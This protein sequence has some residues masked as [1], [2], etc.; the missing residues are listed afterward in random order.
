MIKSILT[1]LITLLISFFALFFVHR[2]LQPTIDAQETEP[3]LQRVLPGADRFRPVEENCSWLGYY[4]NRKI[5]MVLKI[6]TQGYGGPIEMMVGIDTLKQITGIEISPR[7]ETPG[8]G[9]RV[10]EDWFKNQFIGRS[11]DDL[12]LKSEG[13]TI[14]AV[15]GAT[16]SSRAVVAELRAAIN[17]SSPLLA[18]VPAETIGAAQ[19]VIESTAVTRKRPTYSTLS[20]AEKEKLH[21]ALPEATNFQVVE[22]AT[23]W[24]GF[25]KHDSLC[26]IVFKVAPQGY[27]GPIETWVGVGRNRAIKGMVIATPAEGLKETAGLGA[28][29]REKEFLDQFTGTTLATIGLKADGGTIDAVSGATI[30][31]KAV[32]DGVRTGIEQYSKHLKL[33]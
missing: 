12:V 19:P 3:V 32:V 31:S 25:N 11:A 5:G 18:E 27:L 10:K 13:G 17:R 9:D 20:A 23:V 15:T 30:S 28:R 29:V 14:D 24:R 21:T 2:V 7:Q 4:Q 33:R 26:G 16:I 22:D 8:L 1:I 6:T